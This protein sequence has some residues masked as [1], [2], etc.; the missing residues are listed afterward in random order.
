MI[1]GSMPS[2]CPTRLRR[3]EKQMLRFVMLWKLGKLRPFQRKTL[4][5]RMIEGKSGR[6]DQ[7]EK[8]TGIGFVVRCLS[9]LQ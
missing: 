1:F 9:M 7:V 6:F 4:E 3:V 8:M 5:I 2:L